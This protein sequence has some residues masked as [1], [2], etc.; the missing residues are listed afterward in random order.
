MRFE[1]GRR[2]RY[3]LAVL[4]VG[5]LLIGNSSASKM[6]ILHEFTGG[7][8]GGEPNGTLAIDGLG[9]VYGVA[10][11]GGTGNAGVVF[12]L[13]PSSNGW[14]E[15]VLYNFTGGTDGSEPESG[16]II[17]ATGNLFG[18]TGFG[19]TGCGVLF[20]L[21]NQS[22][23]WNYQVLH[24][25]SNGD[26]CYPRGSGLVFDTS[27]NLYGVAGGGGTGGGGTVFELSP[28]GTDAWNFAV[29]HS[30]V[31]GYDGDDPWG[32]LAVAPDGT[33]YG[34]TVYGGPYVSDAGTVFK[35]ANSG[36]VWTEST[37]YSFTGGNNGSNPTGGVILNAAGHLLGTTSGG[38]TDEVG[39]VFELVPTIGIWQLHTLHNFTAGSDGAVPAASLVFDKRGN[40]YST[41]G[42]GGLFQ[43]GTLFRMTVKGQNWSEF[44]VHSFSNGKDGGTP[45]G[46]PLI[47]KSG[48]LYGTA[49]SGGTF[50]QGVVYLVMP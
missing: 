28:A 6:R 44:V 9:N 33:L 29:L 39:T 23:A 19:G 3:V 26:G 13:S 38:G 11:A 14:R 30:F 24:T 46:P 35:V 45:A 7:A 25:F 20:E 21:L 16:L 4:V 31:G 42:G 49:E 50:G 34:T 2:C 22:G 12:E 36:G 48:R 37:I 27:G 1:G 18:T 8:D 15:T 43:Y 17:D 47:D 41:T 40:L 5:I 32:Q 10:P